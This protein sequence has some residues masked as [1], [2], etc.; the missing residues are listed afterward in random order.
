MTST[1]SLNHERDPWWLLFDPLLLLATAGITVIGATLV[2]S[3]TR[4]SAL[5]LVEPNRD[6]LDRQI[7]FMVV[8]LG[9]GVAC[10][11]IEPRQVKRYLPFVYSGLIL[12]LLLVLLI[13]IRVHG[14]RAWFSFGSLRFQPSEPG[15]IVVI[16]ALALLLS[17]RHSTVG[18]RRLGLAL[19]LV[20]L[21]FV[22]VASQPDLGTLLVYVAIFVTVIV[23]SGV[24]ARWIALLA[25]LALLGTIGV[26]RSDVLAGYQEARLTVFLFDID[27]V[28]EEAARYGYNVEQAQIA[29]G[30]GGLRGQGLFQGSQTNS[31]LVPEQQ[32]DFIFTVVGEE[33]G[34]RGA[35]L[36]LGLYALLLYRIWR[37]ARNASSVFG[38]LLCSGV[39]AMFL[40]QVFQAVG[41][42]MGMMPVT[43]IP[44]PLVSYGGSSM[45][46]SLTALGLVAGVHRRRFDV[47]EMRR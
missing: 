46:T 29:I 24:K 17:P 1:R 15:K 40:F 37:T 28:G 2:Y 19:A 26:L 41:M 9:L 33:L 30:N 16:L 13:G 25:L 18:P 11:F 43:G 3:A 23:V 7:L 45:L 36:L 20:G 39:M 8:G 12:A 4:G 10:S 32:T 22:L 14:A 21:P 47:D 44:L 42:T 35:G 31:N 6:F 34:L 27:Q 38:R 5:G